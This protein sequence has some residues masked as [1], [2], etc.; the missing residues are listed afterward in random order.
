MG[1]AK[2]RQVEVNDLPK[3][4]NRALAESERIK[5]GALS[6]GEK[7]ASFFDEA[8]ALFGKLKDSTKRP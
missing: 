1:E 2:K 6:A 5:G 3:D 7:G 4:E 8:D